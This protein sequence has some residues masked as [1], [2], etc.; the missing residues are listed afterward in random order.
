MRWRMASPETATTM[1]R[2]L[3]CAM[4]NAFK[5]TGALSQWGRVP[6]GTPASTAGAS[7]LSSGGDGR[8]P[9]EWVFART[10]NPPSS[11]CGMKDGA[12]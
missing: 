3:Q 10:P 8:S 2:T 9:D 1:R 6:S 7:L 11:L 5:I 12:P 4:C